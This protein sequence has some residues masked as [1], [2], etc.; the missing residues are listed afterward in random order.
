MMH[1]S[2]RCLAVLTLAAMLA[3]AGCNNQT[4]Q[5][6]SPPPEPDI[7]VNTNDLAVIET[8]HGKMVAE[9]FHKDAPNTVA[10]FQKLA[11]KGF[12]DGTTFH[13]VIKGFMIQGGDPLS[14]DPKNL[15]LGSGGPGYSI[16]AE[17][18]DQP[19]RLGVLS[20][21][22]SSHPDSA[23]S[24][25]FI[26]L[27]R[28]ADLDGEYTAFGKLITGEDVLRRIG[29][30]PTKVDPYGQERSVPEERIVIQHIT[31]VPREEALK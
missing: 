17:F 15:T 21:A 4:N 25:F 10:N 23:G 12:Y 24:Q 26:C 3:A 14:K 16:K 31:I 29:D 22:R 30:V 9:F 27:N 19:H 11:R 8:K 13:R 1:K 2:I 28:L 7:P 18:N 5:S 6:V 20:M